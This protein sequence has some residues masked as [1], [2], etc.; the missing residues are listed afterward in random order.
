MIRG[1]FYQRVFSGLDAGSDHNTYDND[2][3]VWGQPIDLG[4]C[5]FGSAHFFWVGLTGMLNARARIVATN[6]PDPGPND[7]APKRQAYL[8]I[9]TANGNDF[10]ELDGVAGERR[11]AVQFLHNGVTGGTID[12]YFHG[13]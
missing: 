11:Y 4:T 13:K 12:C 3:N 1:Y 8:D 7:W 9:T 2:P 10:I 5:T 6:H